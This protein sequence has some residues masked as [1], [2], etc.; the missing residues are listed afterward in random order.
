MRVPF[1]RPL[2]HGHM[3]QASISRISIDD[4]RFAPGVDVLL[5]DCITESAIAGLPVPKAEWLIRTHGASRCAA[6][7]RRAYLGEHKLVGF[8]NVLVS[9]S[10][11]LQRTDCRYRVV[12]VRWRNPSPVRAPAWRCCAAE[13]IAK[14]KARRAAGGPARRD[15][16]RRAEVKKSYRETN[17]VFFQGLQPMSAPQEIAAMTPPGWQG[18]RRA[19]AASRELPQAQIDTCHVIHA[20]LY[21]RTIHI[22]AVVLTGARSRAT[23]L[24]FSGHAVVTMGGSVPM[25]AITCCRPRRAASRLSMALADTDLTMLFATDARDI[26][27]AEGQFTTEPERLMSTPGRHQHRDHNGD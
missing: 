3:E 1:I 14:S 16:G 21:A 6:R 22:P 18:V 19:G 23:L 27:T 8:C 20:G 25:A 24:I 13:A 15:A 11:P 17:C 26:A 2:Q 12:A 7:N 5:R 9:L 4:L 10:P